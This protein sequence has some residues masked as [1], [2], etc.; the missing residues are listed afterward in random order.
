MLLKNKSMGSETSR[1]FRKLWQTNPT[2]RPRDQ[3]M[4]VFTSK[5]NYIWLDNRN[6]TDGKQL[7]TCVNIQWI[8]SCQG[9]RLTATS[10]G[11]SQSRREGRRWG[12]GR[13]RWQSYG[14]FSILF[15][16]I[17]ICISLKNRKPLSSYI[18]KYQSK[19]SCWPLGSFCVFMISW[20]FLRHDNFVKSSVN[21]V[22]FV[23][24]SMSYVLIAF[25]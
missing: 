18:C 21:L 12:E 11:A 7:Y 10:I 16:S 19:S 15:R 5:S 17:F 23:S 14:E 1:P 20:L 6:R 8:Y 2:D 3:H 4:E 13:R 22:P 24:F 9:K 25:F